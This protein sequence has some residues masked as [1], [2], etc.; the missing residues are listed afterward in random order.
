MKKLYRISQWVATHITLCVV[1]VS[2]LA[3]TVPS[4]FTWMQTATVTPM[5]GVVMFGMG[6]TLRPVDFKPVVMHPK[7]MIIGEVA[8]FVIMPSVA[9]ILC[10]VLALPTELAL[11]V[12]LVG[13]CPGGTA[14]NVICY[15]AKGDVALSVAMTGVSTL[16]APIVTPALVFLLAG[17]E[18]SV[19]VLGMFVSI[20]Q[21]V[22]LP[23]TLGLV[24]NRC[25]RKFTDTVTPLLPLVSTIAIVTILGIVVGHNA[26]GILS[27]SLIVAAAVVAH[28]VLGLLLGY[29]AG[30]LSGMDAAK[31]TAISIE[32][33]MQNSGLATSLAATHFAMF[34]MAA[35]PGAMF[36]AW[37]NFSGSIAAQ[38]YRKHSAK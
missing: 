20:L 6:L 14:S 24:V 3:L 4:S 17:E 9:W 12:V 16:I 8:Q 37:H 23:I 32:V 33:G 11:G 1:L 34:P 2:A 30:R 35:V 19:D 36:S 5:L 18:V 27:C 7:A 38:C 31:R 29:W 15:L 21:V 28:N 13:C 22:I 25:F 10:K 26:Q